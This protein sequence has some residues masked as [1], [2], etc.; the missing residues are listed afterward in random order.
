MRYNRGNCCCIKQ[1]VN[2]GCYN[3][4]TNNNKPYS[5]LEPAVDPA[6][7]CG[8]ESP[9]QDQ[10]QESDDEIC[11]CI[12]DPGTVTI[13][14]S[15]VKGDEYQLAVLNLDMPEHR[16]RVTE[17][18]FACNLEVRN[19]PLDVSIQ[20]FKMWDSRHVWIPLAA[21]FR[22][23]NQYAAGITKSVCI[24][25]YDTEQIRSQCISY[26]VLLRFLRNTN[27]EGSLAVQN[28]TMVAMTQRTVS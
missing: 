7:A 5:K 18:S 6:A 2:G 4:N 15:A 20:I 11:I 3:N 24:H 26:L 13:P 22:F 27:D 1:N 17:L 25:V 10:I 19:T 21:P 14:G 12:A 16:K 9:I 23:V 8:D 28:N